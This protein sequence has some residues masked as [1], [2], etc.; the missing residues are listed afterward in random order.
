VSAIRLLGK[1]L[2]LFLLALVLHG[3]ALPV[4]PPAHP[5]RQ[6]P[7]AATVPAEPDPAEEIKPTGPA[8]SLSMQAESAL[9]AGDPG[10]AEMLIERAL[11][12]DP[13]QALYWHIL[14][15][16]RYDQAAYAQAV[17]FFLRAESRMG[18]NGNGDLARRNRQYLE[19]A[20]GKAA[21][22]ANSAD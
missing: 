9:R 8:A 18:D 17:Q 7:P 11:R 22:S 19:A 13:G 12:I 6:Q 3:C 5:G 10:R 20:R 2:A 1:G 14:G 16:A 4:S 15:R 21:Q